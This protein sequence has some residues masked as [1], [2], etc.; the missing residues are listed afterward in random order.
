MYMMKAIRHSIT[1]VNVPLSR[2]ASS[3]GA[4]TSPARAPVSIAD[5]SHSF[6]RV[7]DFLRSAAV[8]VGPRSWTLLHELKNEYNSAYVSSGHSS[9]R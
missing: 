7:T 5:M 1:S 3:G 8:P 4:T 2:P 6:V 9:C